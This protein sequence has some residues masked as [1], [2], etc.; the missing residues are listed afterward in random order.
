MP[1]RLSMF[2]IGSLVANAAMVGIVGGR[3]LSPAL[4]HEPSMEL[5]LEHHGPTSDVVDAAWAQLPEDDRKILRQQLRESWERMAD[6]RSRLSESGHAVYRAALAEPFDES[7][8]R[9]AVA[10]FQMRENRLQ[11]LAEDILISHLGNMPPKARATAAAGLLTPFN[12]RMQRAD[13]QARIAA[14]SGAGAVLGEAAPGLASP[15]AEP[16]PKRD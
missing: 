6:E 2:L 12:A 13:D 4:P 10:I 1:S 8:L 5:Q 11:E 9:D 3:V 15:L 7:R 14:Q 16:P